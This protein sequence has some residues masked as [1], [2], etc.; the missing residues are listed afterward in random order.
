[1]G[2]GLAGTSWWASR[3]KSPGN[4]WGRKRG[5]QGWAMPG[6]DQFLMGEEGLQPAARPSTRGNPTLPVRVCMQSC[7]STPHSMLAWSHQVRHV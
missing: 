7:A 1:M 4:G 6:Q 5:R 3:G 2:N